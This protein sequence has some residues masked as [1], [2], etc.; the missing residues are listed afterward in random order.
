MDIMLTLAEASKVM[1]VS[2]STAQKIAKAGEFPFR[3]VGTQ[4]L[5]PR[6]VLYTELGLELPDEE[7]AKIA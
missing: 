5:I 1:R 2:Y 4:W 7:E 6:S 3:K